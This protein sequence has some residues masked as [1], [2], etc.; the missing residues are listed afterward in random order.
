MGALLGALLPVAGPLVEGLVKGV[1]KL[2]GPKTGDTKREAVVGALGPLLDALA[3][4]GKIPGLPD[5]TTKTALVEMVVQGLKKTGEIN[6]DST[7]R[8]ITV[9]VGAKVTIEL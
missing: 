2:F 3:K 6:A 5:E 8:T 7:Q 1:E 9:P 4:S